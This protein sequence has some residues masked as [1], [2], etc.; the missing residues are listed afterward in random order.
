MFSRKR[1]FR[2]QLTRFRYYSLFYPQL[3]PLPRRTPYNPLGGGS[4]PEITWH[5]LINPQAQ[6][7]FLSTC[8]SKRSTETLHHLLSRLLGPRRSRSGQRGRLLLKKIFSDPLNPRCSGLSLCMTLGARIHHIST[9]VPSLTNTHGFIFNWTYSLYDSCGIIHILSTFIH[10]S[11]QFSHSDFI[12]TSIYHILFMYIRLL[13]LINLF[14]R[15][16]LL[17]L[18]YF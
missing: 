4:G 8:L 6:R 18:P 17:T 12:Q 13:L 15:I 14:S 7:N 5:G 3:A 16:V 10:I 2:V 9:I 11:H 1:N